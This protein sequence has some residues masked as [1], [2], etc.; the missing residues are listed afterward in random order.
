MAM[1][2][3][4][5]VAR[6]RLSLASRRLGTQDPNA[7]IGYGEC[8]SE[9][10]DAVELDSNGCA[11]VLIAQLDADRAKRLCAACPTG[12]ISARAA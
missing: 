4:S 1:V 7:C 11:R 3:A 10:P 6:R 12:A 8:V 9:D 5:E 2:R